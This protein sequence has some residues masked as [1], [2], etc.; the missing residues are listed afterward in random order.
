MLPKLKLRTGL[1]INRSSTRNRSIHP[2]FCFFLSG[3]KL[4]KSK[5]PEIRDKTAESIKYARTGPARIETNGE[6]VRSIA[7]IITKRNPAI[8][9]THG[10]TSTT[11]PRTDEESLGNLL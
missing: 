9:A 11:I 8:S 4:D 3:R 2:F 6:E 1:R 7:A 10:I 5:T